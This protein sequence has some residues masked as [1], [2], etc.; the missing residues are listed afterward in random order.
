[1]VSAICWFYK[2]DNVFLLNRGEFDYG[3]NRDDSR[4]RLLTVEQLNN[5]VSKNSGQKRLVLITTSRHY[6]ERSHLLKKPDFE[7]IDG[8]FAFAQF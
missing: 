4:Y 3:L 2:R 1:M 8:A 6:T 5:F 7:D